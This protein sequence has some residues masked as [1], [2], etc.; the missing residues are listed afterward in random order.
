[1]NSCAPA[2]VENCGAALKLTWR[3][4]RCCSILVSQLQLVLCISVWPRINYIE[5]QHLPS[6]ALWP[7][8][9]WIAARF[10]LAGL[11]ID[12]K[13]EHESDDETY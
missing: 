4:L 12:L 6:V 13:N 3:I 1:M 5:L 9:R 11:V 10:E 8:R 7:R 2:T